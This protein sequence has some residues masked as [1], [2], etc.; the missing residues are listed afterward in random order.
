[1]SINYKPFYNP[2]NNL[3]RTEGHDHKEAAD[4]LKHEYSN[5][6]MNL[7]PMCYRYLLRASH[8]KDLDLSTASIAAKS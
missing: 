7:F 8:K 6:L 4:F 5:V 1:M 3:L 2:L